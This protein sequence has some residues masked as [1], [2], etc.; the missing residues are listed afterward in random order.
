M[1]PEPPAAA[2]R[3]PDPV[4]AE[5]P[6]TDRLLALSDGVVAIALTLLILQITVPAASAVGKNPDSASGLAAA[7]AKSSDD[8]IAYGIS[9]YVISQ[10]WLNH[11][12]V[13]RQI[14]KQVDGLAAWNF[15]FLFTISVMP[16]TSDLLGKFDSNP[17]AVDIF[18]FNLF[19]ANLATLLMLEFGDRHELMS[20]G[21][22]RDRFSSRVHVLVGV[23][24]ALISIGLAWYSTV[25][26][27]CSW[28]LFAIVPQIADGILRLTGRPRRARQIHI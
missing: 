25:L 13:F 27:Q 7:L 22:R 5:R 28:F 26:A 14:D 21:V 6:P 18:G 10:F 16:F 11:H 17:L 15:A 2:A 9:F 24:V 8:W 1:T 4:P 3:P 23:I 20:H 19:L 12:R